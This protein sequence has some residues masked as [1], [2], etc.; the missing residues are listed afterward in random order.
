MDE[1]LIFYK[2]RG[3][4]LIWR[5]IFRILNESRKKPSSHESAFK[6]PR[7]HKLNNLKSVHELKILSRRSL[8]LRLRSKSDL[9]KTKLHPPTFRWSGPQNEHK[10]SGRYSPRLKLITRERTEPSRTRSKKKRWIV[11]KSL[12]S[13]RWQERSYGLP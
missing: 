9:E 11:L 10:Q 3:I 13:L 5:R 2:G 4:Y 6:T 12:S 8:A 1:Y 7:T